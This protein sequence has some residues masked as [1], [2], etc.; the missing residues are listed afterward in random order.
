M[1]LAYATAVKYC[2]CTTTATRYENRH[3]D[4]VYEV[5]FFR[6]RILVYDTIVQQYV[7]RRQLRRGVTQEQSHD[8][9]S[10][11][12][13]MQ[14]WSPDLFPY[15]LYLCI[16]TLRHETPN[17]DRPHLP[18]ISI[19]CALCTCKSTCTRY[20]YIALRCGL[21]VYTW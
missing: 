5:I 20:E 1:S 9:L 10:A 21:L 11:L 8:S 17:I 15:L 7:L 16:I 14:Q 6:T 3:T 19:F 2:C 13:Q 4:Q 12:G 18:S